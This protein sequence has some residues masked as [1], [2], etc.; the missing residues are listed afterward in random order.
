[1]SCNTGGMLSL[2]YYIKIA[3]NIIFI[4]A[5]ILLL[6]LGTIDFL[7]IVT[8]GDERNMKKSV[9]NFIKRLIICVIILILPLFINLVMSTLNV[10]SY[11]ECFANATKANIERLD[12]EAEAKKKLEEEKLK[13]FWKK[14]QEEQN[15]GQSSTSINIPSGGTKTVA[16]SLGLPYYDQCDSRWGKIVYDSG[17]ATLCSSSCGYT[18]LAMVAAGLNGN[19][20]INPY[21]VI[22]DIR[23]IKDGGKT[24]RGYG[25]ASTTELTNGKFIGRYNIKAERIHRKSIM[26]YLKQGKPVIALVPGHYITLSINNSNGKIVLL[27]PYTR[28]AN[29][30]KKIG[31]YDSLSQIEA[32]YGGVSWAAAYQKI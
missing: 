30:R 15:S 31:E 24:H 2:F 32:I 13:V 9:D 10:K 7:K 22:K 20:N 6:L 12:K 25:A 18:S 28:W 8:S 26:N 21:T 17:G 16:N 14:K 3:M 11:K 5:P 29:R 27:D 23:G 1:M 19:G 4:G